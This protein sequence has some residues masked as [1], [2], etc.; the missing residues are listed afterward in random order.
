M[1][2]VLMRHAKPLEEILDFDLR[3]ISQEG[4]ESE[5]KVCQKLK[6]KKIIISK[7]YSS[8]LLRAMQTSEIVAK[9][10]GVPIIVL[11]A[12]GKHFDED[13]LL[14]YIQDAKEEEVLAFMGHMPTIA[15]FANR[16]LGK[17][18]FLEICVSGA[19]V[20]SFDKK[21]GEGKAKLLDYLVPA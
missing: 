7:L 6:E 19:A 18:H 21:R 11:S 16:L 10:F 1:L 8:P 15:Y 4:K 14:R 20:L 17:A 12:L 13:V 9:K 3:P 5:K 2:L